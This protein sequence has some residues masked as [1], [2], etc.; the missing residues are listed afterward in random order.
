MKAKIFAVLNPNLLLIDFFR[1]LFFF[2]FQKES[3]QILLKEECLKQNVNF[4]EVYTAFH[5]RSLIYNLLLSLN[6]AHPDKTQVILP[7]Y[8][9]KVVVNS[10]LKAGLEPIFVDSKKLHFLI[11]PERISSAVNDK[12]LMVFIQ[13]TFGFKQIYDSKFIKSKG[14]L[15]LEDFAHAYLN[16]DEE[17][18]A[19]FKLLSFGQNKLFSSSYGGALLTK[20]KYSIDKNLKTL[21]CL[22]ILYSHLRSSLIYLII[23]TYHVGLG[24]IL[25]KF[26]KFNFTALKQVSEIEKKGK[27]KDIKY[28][29]LPNSQAYLIYKA[30]K[31]YKIN[32]FNHRTKLFEIYKS[33][34]NKHFQFD[35][36]G[37]QGLCF[38]L[39]VD[40]P[41]KLYNFMKAKGVYINLDWTGSNLVPATK[42]FDYLNQNKNFTNSF[43]NSSRLVGL[44]VNLQTKVEEAIR[45]SNL[46]NEFYA[47]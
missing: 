21:N 29:S 45:V 19:D 36:V 1:N 9:C 6:K 23:K 41:L 20:T 22:Q 24:S 42:G 5:A 14:V 33:R 46:I 4:K 8:T 39:R 2:L 12:T 43:N 18:D 32:H 26:L 10:V 40:D 38:P 28:Y 13:H 25:A 35:D 3:Y 34:I 37:Y 30:L 31:N 17:K 47:S 15:I 44:P 7:S 11:D 16:F 27:V